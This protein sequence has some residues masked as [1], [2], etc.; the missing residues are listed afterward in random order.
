MKKAKF[1]SGNVFSEGQIVF[2]KRR[3]HAGLSSTV[4]W[5]D[6]I[7]LLY[8]IDGK[9]TAFL[10]DRQYPL[11]PDT[12]IAV[13]PQTIHSI[14]GESEMPYYI[15][16]IHQGFFLQNELDPETLHF[17]E[18]TV[19][20]K[21]LRDIFE[22]LYEA[23]KQETFRQARITNTTLKLVLY[24]CDN[25]SAAEESG[26]K[27]SRAFGRAKEVI[28]FLKKNFDKPLTLDEI[29]K[30][31]NINKYQLARDFKQSTNVSIFDF[32]NSHRC[33]EAKKLLKSGYTVS[34]AASACGFE[35]L[36]YFSRTYKKY[37][38]VLPN[39]TKRQYEK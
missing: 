7:E 11:L 30:E 15:I 24:L 32:L 5:H 12:L 39:E 23:S 6:H 26:K 10:E 2:Y 27:Q 22:E 18:Y 31:M 8:F 13:G 35:N 29:A 1:E 19:G 34:E 3:C 4:N 28:T 37:I 14:T 20:D 17:P 36:S 9:G 16:F 33:N 21:M 25:Y 38:G